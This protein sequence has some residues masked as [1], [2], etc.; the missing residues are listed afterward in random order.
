MPMNLKRHQQIVR[1]SLIVVLCF[2]YS[3]YCS[4]EN[5]GHWRGAN[6]NS[7]SETATPPT[8]WGPNKNI[9]WKVA[10]PGSGS[11]S[12]VIWGDRVFVVSAVPTDGQTFQFVL[13]CFDRASGK[14]RWQ[15]IATVGQ[16]H[17]GTHSTN[18]FASASPCTDGKHVYAHFGSQG[19]FCYTL[20]GKL[21]W[22]RSDFPR[23]T[24]RGTFG[25]GASPTLAGDLLLVPCD[26]EGQSRLY[27]L[28]KLT[29]KTVWE[30]AR[31]EPSCWAT[32]FVFEGN[33]ESQ[34]IMNGENYVRAYD[35][36]T[37]KELWK[38]G[39]QTQ[40]PVACPVAN[41][42]TVFVGSGFRG[43]FLAA[44]KTDGRGDIEGTDS[45]SWAVDR[46]TPD[47][48]SPL[49]S[50]NRLYF[51]KGKT[52]LLTCLDAKTGDPHYSTMRIP[53][54]RSTYSSP[55]AA[56]GHVYVTGRAGTT[57]VLKD[58][59]NFEMVASNT[60]G[61]PVDTTPAPVGKELFIRGK[62]H[63]FCISE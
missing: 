13:Y 49:L 19:L 15:Q 7:V 14:Q 32:P 36:K 8:E 53:G 33:S 12:P 41:G 20:D 24:M 59:E 55:V 3:Q 51:H 58:G 31:D 10:I 54:I 28:N 25:E 56:G 11:G 37:G 46:D 52:G 23:M 4:G 61:E 50:G 60:V 18:G 21:V 9:K 17:E 38:C 1:Y 27:A 34:V 2:C 48:A 40:R 30:T 35:L 63:L 16:P 57:V 43:S 6:G 22:E 42:D 29:G 39:G 44:F 26:H 45:V 62:N 5:W 47:I